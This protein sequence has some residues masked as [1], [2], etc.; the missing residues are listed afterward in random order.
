MA[1]KEIR[2]WQDEAMF[3]AEALDSETGPTARVVSCNFDPLGSIAFAALGYTGKF[4]QSLADITDEQRRHF[5]SEMEK[6]AIA[7]PLEFVDVHFV[8]S[9]VTR[10]FTHQMVRQR[11]AVYVQEST[12]FAVK[13]GSNLPVGLPPSL[14]ETCSLEEWWED[15]ALGSE[16]GSVPLPD[17]VEGQEYIE[18]YAS[19]AQRARFK[20][21]AVVEHIGEFYDEVVDNGW[22]PA[23]DARGILPTN[24]LTQINYKSNLRNFMAEGGKR[25][26]TQAQFEWRLVFA[27]MLEALREYGEQQTYFRPADLENERDREFHDLMQDQPSY[28]GWVNR[29]SK[30][31]FDEIAKLFA[32][33]CYQKGSCQF[34]ADFDRKC[35]IR[36][37][38]T[39]FAANNIP[40][41]G[42]HSAG[43]VDEVTRQQL[44]PIYP[45][46]WLLDAK[47]AR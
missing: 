7:A 6:T 5:L 37:R 33:I 16:W 27:A 14:E 22:M 43:W 8:V 2:K 28:T 30:W 4:G 24:L 41:N 47:A 36:E 17:S 9:G 40:S 23:E 18:R 42:W 32:P 44:L 31:Q 1:G 35:S 34:E 3:E 45:A 12:R 26:C 21:D 19:D 10:G 29:S 11:T 13:D 38:V 15:Q 25:L 39:K 20:W 46:E